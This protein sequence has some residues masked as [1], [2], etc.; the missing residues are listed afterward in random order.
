MGEDANVYKKF[1]DMASHLIYLNGNIA[2]FE[3][4]VEDHEKKLNC[5]QRKFVVV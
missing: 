3:T 4:F 2:N 5:T 1:N